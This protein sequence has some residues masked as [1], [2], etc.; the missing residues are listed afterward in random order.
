E[1]SNPEQHRIETAM[2]ASGIIANLALIALCLFAFHGIIGPTQAA[3][4]SIVT[5][6]NGGTCN[7]YTASPPCLCPLPYIAPYCSAAAD[8]CFTLQPDKGITALPVC[9]NGGTCTLTYTD[10][11]FTCSCPDGYTDVR[12][13][14]TVTTTAPVSTTTDPGLTGGEIAAIVV[15]ITIAA[16]AI[17]IVILIFCKVIPV[18]ESCTLCVDSCR[19]SCNCQCECECRRSEV[20]PEPETEKV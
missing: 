2:Q 1:R 10:L 7:N 5:C 15:C 9:Q 14:A 6:D 13:N 20:N 4:C 3:N 16:T 19:S 11:Y 18:T 8:Y 12:C 17:V